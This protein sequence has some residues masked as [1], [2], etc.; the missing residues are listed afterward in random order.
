MSQDQEPAAFAILEAEF[1]KG[2]GRRTANIV[3][4]G[5]VNSA[6]K[7]A[8]S[9]WLSHRI[10]GVHSPPQ[11]Q[12]VQMN[13]A[14]T[15]DEFWLEN[16]SGGKVLFRPIC[17]VFVMPARSVIGLIIC[18]HSFRRLLTSFDRLNQ[19]FLCQGSLCH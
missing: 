12:L 13:I 16:E 17:V 6:I 15:F 11:T 19:V 14:P 9:L 18:P 10:C 4:D 3:L 2:R 1:A 7:S 8:F 5:K